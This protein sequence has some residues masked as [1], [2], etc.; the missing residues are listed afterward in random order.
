VIKM[1][2]VYQAD[3]DGIFEGFITIRRTGA[4]INRVWITGLAPHEEIELLVSTGDE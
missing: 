4:V 2:H 1:E 3:E